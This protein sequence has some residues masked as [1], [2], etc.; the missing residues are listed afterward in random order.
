MYRTAPALV[1]RVLIIQSPKSQ[2]GM[3]KKSIPFVQNIYHDIEDEDRAAEY[4]MGRG[5]AGCQSRLRSW[6]ACDQLGS[7][8]QSVD[9][10]LGLAG[11]GLGSHDDHARFIVVAR[12]AS[13]F[14]GLHRLLWMC[15][16]STRR[17]LFGIDPPFH[18]R[19]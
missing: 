1:V 17:L 16:Q 13:A 11:P 6:P 19:P 3:Q 10:H 7:C 15:S 2:W 5:N 8:Q 4:P 18:R 12:G 14:R 9:R